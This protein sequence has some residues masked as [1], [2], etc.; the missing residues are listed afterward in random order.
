MA[1]K[2]QNQKTI[3]NAVTDYYTKNVSLTD[4]VKSIFFAGM[5]SIVGEG[6]EA[7]LKA[8]GIRLGLVLTPEKL[9]QKVLDHVKGAEITHFMDVQNLANSL[10]LVQLT[11]TEKQAYI[12][13][14][15]GVKKSLVKK[16]SKFT[17]LMGDTIHGKIAQW[18]KDHKGFTAQELHASNAIPDSTPKQKLYYDEFLAYRE[19]FQE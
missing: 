2:A 13:E 17:Q 16:S 18:C 5:E 15:S 4:T 14:F 6:T 19:F 12:I 11:N 9:K 1:T 7:I 3:D 8:E 10:D